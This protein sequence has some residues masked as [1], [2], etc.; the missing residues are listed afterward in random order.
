MIVVGVLV[1]ADV[2]V[3]L[4]WAASVGTV[5]YLIGDASLENLLAAHV[6]P[7]SGCMQP[8]EMMP[9]LS[10]PHNFARCKA[11]DCKGLLFHREAPAS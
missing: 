9:H 5:N 11:E 10:L 1:V 4:L 2:V 7:S 8:L 3:V 6:V